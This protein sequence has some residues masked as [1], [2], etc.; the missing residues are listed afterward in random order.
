[1]KSDFEIILFFHNMTSFEVR[2]ISVKLQL[3]FFYLE[4]CE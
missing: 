2:D 1:M 4:N 3:P